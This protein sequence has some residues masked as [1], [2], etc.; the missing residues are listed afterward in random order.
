MALLFLVGATW[1]AIWAAGRK[2]GHEPSVP[3]VYATVNDENVKCIK[4]VALAE[5][6]IYFFVFCSL[7]CAE[8]S[9]YS[10][11]IHLNITSLFGHTQ[12]CLRYLRKADLFNN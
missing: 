6:R 1:G 9:T 5:M 2:G 11:E 10:S 7:F 8:A 3:P 4:L 12:K